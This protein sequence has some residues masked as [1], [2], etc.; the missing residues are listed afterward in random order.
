D[1]P[2][3]LP[4]VI[5]NPF[6]VV[7]GPASSA[8]ENPDEI[9]KL[10][11]CLFGQPS[12]VLVPGDGKELGSGQNLKIGVVLSGGQAPG[13][14]NVISGIFDYLQDRCKG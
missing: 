1:Q 14:H 12:A 11:P 3:P 10:F 9:A 7:D 6:N 2:L 5:R 13:G 4:S 8:A